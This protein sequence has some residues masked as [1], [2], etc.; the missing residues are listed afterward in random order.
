M[1]KAHVNRS[2][3]II[4]ALAAPLCGFCATTWNVPA[5][6]SLAACVAQ[7]TA[8][9]EIVIAVGPYE[10]ADTI[11]VNSG[12]SIRG[13]TGN[14]EDVILRPTTASKRVF[15]LNHAEARVESLSLEGA[16]CRNN[17][18]G[19]FI[20]VDTAGGMV[21]NCVIRNGIQ[22]GSITT[23]QKSSPVYLASSAALLTHCVITNNRCTVTST[24]IAW[25]QVTVGVHADGKARIEHCLIADNHDVGD[26][27]RLTNQGVWGAGITGSAFVRGCTVVNNTGFLVG[28]ISLTAGGVTNCIVAGNVSRRLA[29]DNANFR[30]GTAYDKLVRWTLS[31][32]AEAIAPSCSIQNAETIFRDYA[33]KDYRP[34]PG[35]LA[36]DGGR[37]GYAEPLSDLGGGPRVLGSG[38][39]LGCYEYAFDGF[40]AAFR[41]ETPRCLLLDDVVFTASCTGTNDDAVLRYRWDFNGDGTIDRVTDA[42]VVT[43]RYPTAGS[44]SVALTVADETSGRTITV[45]RPDYLYLVPRTMHFAAAAPN[46][47]F[48]YD[49]WET[50]ATSLQTAIDAA[51]DGVEIICAKDTYA[52]D[53][54]VSLE[55]AV[56]IR[57][58]TGHPDDV[59]FTRGAATRLFYLNHAA[60]RLAGVRLTGNFSSKSLMGQALMVD[61]VGGV[62]SNCTLSGASLSVNIGTSQYANLV[63]L[64]SSDALMTHCFVTNNTGNIYS[65]SASTGDATLCLSVDRGGRVENTLVADNASTGV[66]TRV[67]NYACGIYAAKAYL[68]NCT[69]INNVDSDVGGI[70]LNDG[71]AVNCVV[72][73][74]RTLSLAASNANV[75]DTA[76]AKKRFT[77]CATT[78]EPYTDSCTSAPI[79]ELVRDAAAHDYRPASGSPL[80]DNGTVA[81][82]TPPAVDLDG[83]PRLQG[84]AIDI[85]CFEFDPTR[86]QASFGT[87]KAQAILPADVVL[88]ASVTGVPSGAVLRYS[89]DFDGDGDVD[90]VTDAPVVTNRYPTAGSVTVALTVADETSG[91]TITVVRPDYLYLVPRTMHFAATAP[92]SGFPYD[93]WENAATNLQTAVD[94]AIDGVEIICASGTYA[95]DTTVSLDKGISIRG[96]TGHPDDVVF[97]R[98]TATRLFYLNHARAVLS[99][100]RLTGV[101]R[102]ANVPGQA[103][104]V[105]T[106]GGTASN[107]ALAGASLTCEVNTSQSTGLIYL[108]SAD[109]LMTHC[110][111]TNNAGAISAKAITQS[112]MTMCV[113]V[114]KGA[115]V[116]NCLFADNVDA[117]DRTTNMKFPCAVWVVNGKL[118]NCTIVR[119]TGFDVGGIM[120]KAG[121]TVNSVV[122]GNVANAENGDADAPIATQGYFAAC[123]VGGDPAAL[124]A[125]PSRCRWVPRVGSILV[126][127]GTLVGLAPPSL[128]LAGNPR[129]VRKA[130]DIGCYECQSGARTLLILR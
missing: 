109:A 84:A 42:P 104:F 68:R 39:D 126:N 99:G 105:D 20:Y 62:V 8:G 78:D 120:Q 115:R 18:S 102:Q 114:D 73:G 36:V 83:A 24:D 46:S 112:D 65:T 101:Y 57:G 97:T 100:L 61:T 35:S 19:N 17:Y 119:N 70:R 111:V 103:L 118:A 94:A 123:V 9:D 56:S 45:V 80:I 63:Y 85:G 76:A 34:A 96:Q 88:R 121:R 10:V 50:A 128:D 55:K 95:L 47:A 26:R 1:D 60:A 30:R 4:C 7:A 87:D 64:N 2:A 43:N 32:D 40:D 12:L 79:D 53:A 6:G 49:T 106:V 54:M 129:V 75:L 110:F 71:T 72:A 92:N 82:F 29:T 31:D 28:G 127:S 77:Y 21:S 44:V 74:N 3:R 58:Q 48:P 81:G 51:V 14:P 98:G 38:I 89:W 33:A 116:E 25:G 113:T 27:V 66:R 69:V 108:N 117:A 5:D 91:R 59:V 107:C 93:T 86:F 125:N 11:T 23:I 41:T 13:A 15:T 52:L 16:T 67:Q 130:I 37:G 90:R 22:S 124:F 122:A